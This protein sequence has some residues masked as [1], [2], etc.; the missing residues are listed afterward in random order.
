MKIEIEV[1]DLSKFIDA[2]N[3]AYITFDN[4]VRQ[5]IFLGLGEETVPKDLLEAFKKR[6]IKQYR[7]DYMDSLYNV[8]T[9]ESLILK[10]VYTQLLEMEKEKQNGS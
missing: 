3:H 6:A 1:E 10:N 5:S 4:K 2:Y 9:S 7:N 8:V